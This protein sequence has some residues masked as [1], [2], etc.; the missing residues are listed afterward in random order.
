VREGISLVEKLRLTPE[1]RE[2][3]KAQLEAEQRLRAAVHR[4]LG[5][6]A[7]LLCLVAAVVALWRLEVNGI[8]A[9]HALKLGGGAYPWVLLILGVGVLFGVAT[10][11]VGLVV[12][13]LAVR[14][15]K[16]EKAGG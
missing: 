8:S 1:E 6:L 2:L 13:W 7:A 12:D 11:W 15:I 5:M 3:L 9:W 4:Q 10:S 14:R 16:K